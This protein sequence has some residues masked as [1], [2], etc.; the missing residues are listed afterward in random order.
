MS[1]LKVY[2]VLVL[3]SGIGGLSFANYFLEKQQTKPLNQQ[4][5]LLVVSKGEADQTNTAWAQG[6]IA[7]PVNEADSISMHIKDTLNAASSLFGVTDFENTVTLE[8]SL[9][10]LNDAISKEESIGVHYIEPT[11]VNC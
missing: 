2:D 1:K 8:L 7:A 5:S 10:L 3:G 4:L 6:G 9:L 11:T